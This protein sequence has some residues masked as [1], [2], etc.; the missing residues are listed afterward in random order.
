MFRKAV[1]LAGLAALS[2]AFVAPGEAAAQTV[3]ERFRGVWQDMEGKAGACKRSDWN[4]DAQTDTHIRI[5][6]REIDFHETACRFASVQGS[7]LDPA[8]GAVRL[9]LAC[10]GEGETWRRS[11]IWQV[12]RIAGHAMLVTTDIDRGEEMVVVYQRCG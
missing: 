9:T 10:K 12:R 3:P 1:V 5:G 6:A 11:Q 7:K 2:L 4:T 8:D